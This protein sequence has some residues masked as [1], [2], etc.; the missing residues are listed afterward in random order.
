MQ[1]GWVGQKLKYGDSM[2]I[3]KAEMWRHREYG[4]IYK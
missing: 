1:R 3:S 2:V 4:D